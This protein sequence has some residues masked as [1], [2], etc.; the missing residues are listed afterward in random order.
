MKPI[1]ETGI[2]R[3]K[4][5]RTVAGGVLGAGVLPALM[6]PRAEA[7]Q[8]PDRPVTFIIPW[9]PGGGSDQMARAMDPDF[10]KALGVAVPVQDS[11]GATGTIG[12]EKML[13]A[14]ADGYTIGDLIGDTMVRVAR[15]LSPWKMS[16]VEGVCRVMNTPLALFVNAKDDRFKTWKD[17]VAHA[18]AHPGTLKFAETGIGSIPD[19][20]GHNL[21]TKGIKM[22]GVPFGKPELRYA[23]L[24]GRHVDA[25]IDPAGNVRRYVTGGQFRP[26]LVFAEK[27]LPPLPHVPAASEVDIMGPYFFESRGLVV[28]SGTSP[29]IIARLEKAAHATYNGAAFNKFVDAFRYTFPDAWMGSAEYRKFLTTQTKAMSDDLRRFGLIHS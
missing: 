23:S 17:L 20:I 28:R 6:S 5:L 22:T 2:T 19:L 11:P 26:L 16:A 4:W 10:S 9:G 27:R 24:L 15:G 1:A 7:G 18:K 25:L 8:Y 3:R 13:L 21:A 12:I 29:A 14:P